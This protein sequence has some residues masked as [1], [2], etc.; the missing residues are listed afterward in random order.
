MTSRT[1]KSDL[2]AD[3]ATLGLT[4][5]AQTL[6]DFVA[7]A[8]QA[9]WPPRTLLEALASAELAERH[10]RSLERRFQRSRIGRFK[11]IADFD[12]NWPQKIDRDGIRARP[13]PWSSFP[14][15]ATSSCSAPT[16]WAK[17]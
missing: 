1:P 10:R 16:A 2:A 6:D 14:K 12:W 4:V 5:T 15:P 17:P 13:S 8:T 11:P 3:L 7:R 9:R